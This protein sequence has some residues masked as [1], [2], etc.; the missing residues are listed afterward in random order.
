MLAVPLFPEAG[1]AGRASPA[2]PGVNGLGLQVR[3]VVLLSEPFLP[4]VAGEPAGSAA[5]IA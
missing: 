4:D 1:N 3:L 2:F 5:E